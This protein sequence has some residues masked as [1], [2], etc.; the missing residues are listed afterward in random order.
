MSFLIAEAYAKQPHY[1]HLSRLL[2]WLLEAGIV[3]GR[4]GVI[5]SWG[6]S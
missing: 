3:S 6:V 2:V 1:Q 5:V 4:E